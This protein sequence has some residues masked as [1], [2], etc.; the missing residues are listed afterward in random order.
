MFRV[1]HVFLSVHFSL[2]FTCLER[3]DLFARLNVKFSCIFVTFSCGVLGQMWYLFV[4]I[5]DLA[6]LLCT[7]YFSQTTFIKAQKRYIVSFAV[8]A[9]PYNS[10]LFLCYCK[11]IGN[12]TIKSL[13]ILTVNIAN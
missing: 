11:V 5:S 4:S 6:F 13:L 9:I 3:A 1:C 10:K 8:W 2:V 7:L 12:L